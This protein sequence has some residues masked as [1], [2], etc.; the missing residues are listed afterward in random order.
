MTRRRLK[1]GFLSRNSE[2]STGLSNNTGPDPHTLLHQQN[3]EPPK[4]Q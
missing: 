1:L 3:Q 2:R 4:L